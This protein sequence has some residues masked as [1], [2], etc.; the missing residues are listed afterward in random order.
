MFYGIVQYVSTQRVAVLYM[1]SPQL[2]F[3]RPVL[4]AVCATNVCWQPAT[5][6]ALSRMGIY[7]INRSYQNNAGQTVHSVIVEQVVQTGRDA[8][9]PQAYSGPKL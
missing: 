4:L 7:L 1:V 5:R 9:W 2:L 8:M 3:L 6:K